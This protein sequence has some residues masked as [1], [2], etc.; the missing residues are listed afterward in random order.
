MSRSNSESSNE[1]NLVDKFFGS[2]LMLAL[3]NQ[4]N[5][6]DE[7]KSFQMKE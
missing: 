6:K 2:I 7:F 5:I 4:K 3:A 1:H